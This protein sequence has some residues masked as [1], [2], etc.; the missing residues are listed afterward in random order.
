M[1]L[2]YNGMVR[3]IGVRTYHR[4]YPLILFYSKGF[5]GVSGCLLSCSDCAVSLWE[6]SGIWDWNGVRRGGDAWRYMIPVPVG[7]G[8]FPLL[9]FVCTW[10][11]PSRI[12]VP[13]FANGRV[14]WALQAIGQVPAMSRDSVLISHSHALLTLIVAEDNSLFKRWE[15]ILS[16]KNISNSRQLYL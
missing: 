10:V 3:W 1:E 8:C 2:L 6:D 11:S 12:D 15:V 16:K 14:Y 5:L 9:D 7:R 13:R 4:Q